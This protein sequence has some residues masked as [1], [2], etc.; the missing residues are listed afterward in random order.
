MKAVRLPLLIA[1][2]ILAEVL[3]LVTRIG[4]LLAVF[5]LVSNAAQAQRR[6]Q[7]AAQTQNGDV[8]ETPAIGLEYRIDKKWSFHLDAQLR[9]DQGMSRV[10]S[11]QVRPGLEY[12]LTPNWAL[13]A[14]YVQYTRYL[15][16]ARQ[17]RGPFQ[18]ILYRNRVE[19]LPIVGRLRWEE[20]FYDNSTVLVRTR[21]LAGVRIPLG[22]PWELALSNEVYINVGV[23]RPTTQAGFAQ[24]HAFI[25]FG[26][27]L[28]SW[29]KASAGYEL[30]T[31]RS[32]NGFRNEH[33]FKLN[34]IFNLN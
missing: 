4:V 2:D 9:F 15:Q 8:W 20:L 1:P 34:I 29:A 13:A 23:D 22:A 10:R 25:G 5:C 16:G 11:L 19:G 33:N 6:Q 3:I 17:S 26:R 21:A 28:S 14:G 24:N 30:E 32:L 18:D 12:A 31:I 27:P 7:Q